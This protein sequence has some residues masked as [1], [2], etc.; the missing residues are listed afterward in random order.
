MMWRDKCNTFPYHSLTN[1][2]RTKFKIKDMD[3]DKDKEMEQHWIVP[4]IN[5]SWKDVTNTHN[6]EGSLLYVAHIDDFYIFY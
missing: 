1:K 2:E 4:Q 3:D 6:E 5:R